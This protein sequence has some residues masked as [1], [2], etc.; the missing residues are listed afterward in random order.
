M[1]I[2]PHGLMTLVI[3]AMSSPALVLAE[4]ENEANEGSNE[5]SEKQSTIPQTE[6]EG[7]DK[8]TSSINSNLILFVTISAIASVLAYSSWKV[9]K[10]RRRSAPKTTV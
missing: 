1:K 2:Y 8:S 10:I 6:Y 5:I 4:T 7:N 9:Y 3:L